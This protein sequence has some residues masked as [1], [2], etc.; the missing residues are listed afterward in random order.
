MSTDVHLFK[1][2]KCGPL[3]CTCTSTITSLSAPDTSCASPDRGTI[4]EDMKAKSSGPTDI[5]Q[6]CAGR[7]VGRLTHGNGNVRIYTSPQV[8]DLLLFLLHCA[9]SSVIYAHATQKS[10]LEL[11]NRNEPFPNCVKC[12]IGI[13]SLGP[14]S[15]RQRCCSWW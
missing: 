8:H 5:N 6:Y 15:V 10:V 7:L 11:G 13:E 4:W 2:T 14:S 12:R 1:T 9:W 3:V